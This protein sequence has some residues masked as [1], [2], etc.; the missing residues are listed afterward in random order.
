MNKNF[1]A[2]TVSK[3]YNRDRRQC[4]VCGSYELE[5]VPHHIFFK[6]ELFKKCVRHKC[7]GALICKHCH[8]QIHHKGNKK[9]EKQLKQEALNM[10]LGEIKVDD[11]IELVKIYYQKHGHCRT[12]KK[13][14]K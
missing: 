5:S 14:N 9:F 13:N 4:R 7:N 10:F 3:I 1:T 8:Y 6:S 11:Y 12:R 2:K